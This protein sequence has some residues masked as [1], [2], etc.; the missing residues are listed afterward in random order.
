MTARP[1]RMAV[2]VLMAFWLTAVRGTAQA[3]E[4]S[5]RAL[6]FAPTAVSAD[7]SIVVGN[8]GDEAIRWAAAGGAVGLGNHTVAGVSADG[9]VIIGG[10][11]RWTTQKGWVPLAGLPAGSNFR[12][13]SVS[14]DGSVIVGSSFSGGAPSDDPLSSIAIRWSAGGSSVVIGGVSET[15]LANAV[16]A[17]GSVVVGFSDGEA[18]RWTAAE[19]M[20]SLDTLP[21]FVT[22]PTG[23]SAD[24]SVIVGDWRPQGYYSG[25][26]GYWPPDISD[27]SLAVIWNADGHI[28][29]LSDVLVD[30]GLDV[31]AWKLY[32]ADAISADGLT[33]VGIGTD[34]SG[35]SVGW[36]A[37]IP[38]P[39]I[40]PL[41][42]A[43]ALVLPRRP[44]R[45]RALAPRAA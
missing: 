39:A 1:C 2:S 45:R 37:T 30:L 18:I 25:R 43:A 33:I 22:V 6:D 29:P 42:G 34:P 7:G 31:T 13:R 17:D 36:V 16:S 40:V 44:I 5:L 20:V 27:I 35:Q 24:G 21:G 28:R 11:D 14:A 15:D 12:A 9:S 4:P 3:A 23:I 32:Q 19:G 26:V 38:E 8:R 10:A 41:L